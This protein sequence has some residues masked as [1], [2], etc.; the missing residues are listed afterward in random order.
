MPADQLK[1]ALDGVTTWLEEF[2]CYL[3]RCNAKI[4][5]GSPHVMFLDAPGTICRMHPRCYLERCNTFNRHATSARLI[6]CKQTMCSKCH[7]RLVP[8]GMRR[9]MTMLIDD[10]VAR[11]THEGECYTGFHGTSYTVRIVTELKC[12]IS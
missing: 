8:E 2:Q 1:L 9:I 4:H 5:V 7:K 12:P 3:A 11:A 6:V 10:N